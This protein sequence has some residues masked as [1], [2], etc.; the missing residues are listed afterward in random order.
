M[1]REDVH[2]YICWGLMLSKA[3]YPLLPEQ[4]AI[5]PHLHSTHLSQI[6]SLKGCILRVLQTSR[7]KPTTLGK[8][9]I[10]R[11]NHKKNK[12]SC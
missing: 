5:S 2:L 10:A 3:Q 8:A 1:G 6:L 4:V 7:L 12:Y 9:F 11:N